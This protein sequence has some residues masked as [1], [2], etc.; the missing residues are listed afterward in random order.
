MGGFVHFAHPVNRLRMDLLGLPAH[1]EG[2]V[3]AV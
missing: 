2:C 3:Q 1:G